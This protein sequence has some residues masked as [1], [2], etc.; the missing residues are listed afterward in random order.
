[1]SKTAYDFKGE[2][3][4]WTGDMGWHFVTLPSKLSEEIKKFGK[5]YGAGFIKV[6]VSV[7]ESK[8]TTALFPHKDSGGY[9][10]SIKQNIRKK[11]GV[12][13]GDI[14]KVSITLK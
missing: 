14:I 13:E 5:R 9:L 8:W 7:G 6:D 11:E 4:R 2:V 10:L 1:M 3:W 12:W